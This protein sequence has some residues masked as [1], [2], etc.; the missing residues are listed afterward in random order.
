MGRKK[1]SDNESGV[2]AS[3]ILGKLADEIA[4]AIGMNVFNEMQTGTKILI[5]N[6]RPRLFP[7][8]ENGNEKTIDDIFRY[9]IPQYFA[10][11]R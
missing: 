6:S 9:D 5:L 2:Y 10:N 1:Q 3:P 8:Y 4:E 7:Q 11:V